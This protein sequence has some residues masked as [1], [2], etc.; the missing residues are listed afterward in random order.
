ML[1]QPIIASSWLAAS[2]LLWPIQPTDRGAAK[3]PPQGPL[4]DWRQPR[5]CEGAL[6]R[7]PRRAGMSLSLYCEDNSVGNCSLNHIFEAYLPWKLR[8]SRN[9]V[10]FVHLNCV[11][12]FCHYIISS[13]KETSTGWLTAVFSVQQQAS[14]HGCLATV[15]D[16]MTACC[17]HGYDISFISFDFD[18]WC[19][20]AVFSV[21]LLTNF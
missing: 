20:L 12:I 4:W 16:C 17:Q 9:K 10:S 18:V 14:W 19:S 21:I 15:V 8:F 11:I 5:G 13:Y 7:T 6:W 1:F 2:F 3:V